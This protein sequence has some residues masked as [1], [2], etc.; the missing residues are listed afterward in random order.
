[1]GRDFVPA[2]GEVPADRADQLRGYLAMYLEVGGAVYAL[3]DRIAKESS[4]VVLD[5]LTDRDDV[6]AAALAAV[7]S[8]RA[9]QR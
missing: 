3:V 4:D 9:S 2:E 1:M 5:G 6:L 8:A 7:A